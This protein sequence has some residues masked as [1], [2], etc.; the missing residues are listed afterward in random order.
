MSLTKETMALRFKCIRWKNFL[1]T[2]N[3]FT[4]IDFQAAETTLIIGENGAGKSTLLDALA[5]V[6]FGVPFRKIN[7][8]QLTNSINLKN[9]VVE[10]EFA[11]GNKEYKIIR[12]MRPGIFEI[13]EDGVLLNQDAAARDYQLYLEESILKLNYKT[14]TQIVILG[15]ASYKPFMQLTL[16][17]RREIIEDLLD[18]QIFTVMNAVLKE[19]LGDTKDALVKAEYDLKLGISK[20][21]MQEQYLKTLNNDRLVRADKIDA[22]IKETQAL[23]GPLQ[24]EIAYQ[25]PLVDAA[26]AGITDLDATIAEERKLSRELADVL[27][28][29]KTLSREIQ[30]YEANDTCPTCKQG[31]EDHFK[32]DTVA[33]KQEQFDLLGKQEVALGL[34]LKIIA[35]RQKHIAEIQREVRKINAKINDAAQAIAG[36]ERFIQTLILEKHSLTEKVGNLQDEK[37]K[38]KTMAQE[39]VGLGKKR[40]ELNEEKQY[41]EMA[42]ALLKDSGIKTKIIRKFIP[43][44][45]KLVNKYL[46]AMDFFVQ[47]TLDEEFNETIKSRH[48]D[49]FSYHSFSE[50]EK[51][52]IDLALLFTWRA[53]AK[54]KKSDHTNLL[55]LDEIFDSSL[56]A[57]GME[58]VMTLLN[59]LSEDTHVMVISHKPEA[60]VD[61]FARTLKFVRKQNYSVLEGA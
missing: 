13:F 29:S 1:A 4:E 15:S 54:L 27:A 45:N 18:I 53:I 31:I 56:D 43:V 3:A 44:I 7:K 57:A 40:A 60:L 42:A 9:C 35:G 23:I 48:R 39:V 30:F 5:F 10:L 49:S 26:E 33:E 28:Q 41:Y 50:G 51:Q 47:F 14:F 37:D 20:T 17:Q 12:G 61:K 21:K 38:L 55:I 22:R 8:P 58:Y 36:H 52:R 24:D 46:Q 6:A 2:G 32:H 11:S 34:K 19:K 16:G 59:L 25:Q